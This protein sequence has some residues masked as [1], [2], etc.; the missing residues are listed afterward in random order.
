MRGRAGALY[1]VDGRGALL[2]LREPTGARVWRTV[3]GGTPQGLAFTRGRAWVSVL[4]NA[5]EGSLVA[6][7]LRSG[8][9]LARIPLG[10]GYGDV[11]VVGGR[12]WTQAE[13]LVGVDPRRARLVARADL[14]SA[15]LHPL[16]GRLAG[17]GP[18]A[19]EMRDARTG[20]PRGP[21]VAIG[22]SLRRPVPAGAR[23]VLVPDVEEGTLTPV[24]LPGL[25]A[26]TPTPVGAG[27]TDALVVGGEVWVALGGEGVIR[28]IPLAAL[29]GGGR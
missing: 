25:R 22:S 11:A 26:G 13:D 9:V 15:L 21:V 16:A 20:A 29:T 17:V 1:V 3:L 23:A 4:R 7:D 19:I 2:R 28:R 6:V 12:V 24:S 18:G 10:L 14:D 27:P 5:I 8:R